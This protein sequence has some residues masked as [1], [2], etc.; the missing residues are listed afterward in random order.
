[1]NEAAIKTRKERNGF[2]GVAVDRTG[3]IHDANIMEWAETRS[4]A[5]KKARAQ[6]K[7][8]GITVVAN[9]EVQVS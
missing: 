5:A 1:M 7:Q 6:C 3:E 9:W 2:Y 4:E 8:A